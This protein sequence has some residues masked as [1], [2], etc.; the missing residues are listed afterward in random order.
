MTKR[1]RRRSKNVVTMAEVANLAGVSTMTVSNVL[2]NK[3]SVLPER[4][5]AV[6]EAMDK[7]NYRPNVAARA[8]ASAGSIRIGLLYRDVEN[9]LLGAMLVGALKASARFGFQL[10]IRSYDET[11]PLD[12]VAAF[13]V[14]EIDGLLLPPPLCELVSFS[15]I[16]AKLSIPMIGLAPGT[17][18]SDIPAVRIDDE[19]AAY[20]VTHLLLEKGHRRIGFV[21][22][23]GAMVGQ[24]RLAGVQRALA[25]HGEVLEERF[26]WEARPI[27]EAGLALADMVC[28]MEERPTAILAGS[29]DIAA[30]FVNV[31]HR[32]GLHV[33]EDISIVG[34]D[35]T[36]IAVKIWPA[37]TTVRQPLARIAEQATERLIQMIRNPEQYTNDVIYIP[38]EIIQR[39]S[40][41]ER[42]LQD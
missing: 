18:L 26:I 22:L 34:F 36:P 30:A 8:L 40:V 24:T 35:D 7:L 15:G 27:Y 25:E 3:P 28:K 39:A 1:P 12:D 37:L 11:K 14:S 21:K 2:N 10:I 13:A 41:S 19:V 6:L 42:P 16:S 23:P 4:R 5:R 31:M 38:H 17:N 20:E 33:P 29:D 32:C 9:A